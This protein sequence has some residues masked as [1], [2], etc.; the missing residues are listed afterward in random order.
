MYSDTC[1]DGPDGMH[2]ADHVRVPLGALLGK[3]QFVRFRQRRRD[4]FRQKKQ[5][6]AERNGERETG[7]RMV[8][9]SWSMGMKDGSVLKDTVGRPRRVGKRSL[10]TSEKCSKR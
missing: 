8:I 2:L 9:H 10:K 4:E 1:I 5:E 3:Q 7:Q 6:G